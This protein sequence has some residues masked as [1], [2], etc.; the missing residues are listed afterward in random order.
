MC[1]ILFYLIL[2]QTSLKAWLPWHLGH[3][4]PMEAKKSFHI[5]LENYQTNDI[6]IT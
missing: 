2:S 3:F 6:F 1:N 5:Q 4:I